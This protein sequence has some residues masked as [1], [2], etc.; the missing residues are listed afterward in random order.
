MDLTAWQRICN[1]ILGGVVRKRA[2]ADKELS[3]NL[4]KGSMPMM[5]EVYLATVIVTTIAIA[6]IS[7]GVVGIFFFPEI[8]VIAF[9]EGI[10]AAASVGPCFEW[11]YWNPDL[12]NPALPGN[13]CPE[14][15]LQVFPA[16]LKT[17]I[18]LIGG[19]LI[20]YVAYKYNKGGAAREAKRR[21][22]MIEKYLPYAASYTAAMSAAN[23][24]PSKIFR[25]LAMNKDIYGDV[26]DDAAMVYRDVTLLGYDLITAMKMSVDR[27]ASVW[28][29]EFFQGMVGT[30]TAGGQL[31]LYF[32]NRAEHYMRENRTRLQMFLESIALLAESYIVVAVA[33]PLFLIVMLVIMFWVSGSG[34][35]M[36]EGM[37]YGI[38]LGFIPMIHIAYAILVYTSSKEQD[39]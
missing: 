30:L 33:M 7:W 22:D 34:A 27:A 10:Q 4:V 21:G 31:K 39:M 8:G 28:L 37:L 17:I 32:L 16:F 5:P 25:S 11:E 12:I 38:V 3:K 9:Y 6:L 15:S 29:T 35:Q 13:G 20:P 1:R 23:A 2:R 14:Y 18:V 26:A 24:T 36:S 19:F